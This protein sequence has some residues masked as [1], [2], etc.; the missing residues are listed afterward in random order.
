[1]NDY[2][3]S[4]MTQKWMGVFFW[5]RSTALK[6]ATYVGG[7]TKFANFSWLGFVVVIFFCGGSR[8]SV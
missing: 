2:I 3:C 5:G 6:K 1:M 8:L 4:D 7:T